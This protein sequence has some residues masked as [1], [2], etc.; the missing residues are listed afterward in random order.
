MILNYNGW[1]A[2]DKD[3]DFWGSTFG[4]TKKAVESCIKEMKDDKEFDLKVIKIKFI[5]VE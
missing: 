3:G 5:E 2:R 1:V 4:A